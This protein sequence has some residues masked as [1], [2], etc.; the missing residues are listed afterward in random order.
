M[1]AVVV[2]LA[3]CG[4]GESPPPVRTPTPL[5]PTTTGTIAGEVR[6]EGT[7]P[8]MGTLQLGSFAECATQHPAPVPAGDALVA[9]GKVENAFVWLKDGLGDRVF[10]VPTSP[11]VVDQVGCLYRPRVVGAQVG[12]TIRFVNGDP[13]LHNV[14]GTPSK[15]S[16][17]NVSLAR[18]GAEREIRIDHPEIMVSVRCDLH[19]WM[20]GWIG[21]VDHPFFAVTGPDGAFRLEGVPPGDYTVGVWHERFGRGETR[22]SLAPRGTATATFTLAASK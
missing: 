7:V 17:W 20:Q 22:V 12:Q 13:F 15:S 19:P 4:G 5:D 1:L 14:H 6:F 9:N 18:K 2:L 10:A 21:V 11:V 8:P 3:A 16:A